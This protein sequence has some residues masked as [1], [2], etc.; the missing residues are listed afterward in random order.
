MD[1]EKRREV[2]E[3]AEAAQAK[4]QEAKTLL[5]HPLLQEA[6][7]VYDSTI[8]MLWKKTPPEATEERERLH[9]RWAAG[10]VFHAYL[11]RTIGAGKVAAE[12]AARIL[13][14]DSAGDGKRSSD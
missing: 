4:A 12:T 5:D 9:Q 3:K 10:Q 11:T 6:L 1:A 8:V 14:D 7:A 2:Q 13:A